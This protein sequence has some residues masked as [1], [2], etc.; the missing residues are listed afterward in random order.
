MNKNTISLGRIFGIPLNV[1]SSWFLI[2][3]LLSWMLAS[4]YYPREF[5]GWPLWQYW[6]MGMFTS[7][8]LFVSVLLHELG[9]SLVAR[10]F[11]LPVQRIT[12]FVFGGIAQIAGEP[13][14]ARAEFWIALAGPIVSFALAALFHLITP[15]VQGWDALF[16]FFKY[17]AFI[18]LILAG[19]N[20]IPGF[21]LDGGRIFRSILWGITKNL[22]KATF[23]AANVGRFFAFAFIFLG[24][25]QIIAGHIMDGLWTIFIGLFLE[26]A[27]SSQIQQQE[28][29]TLLVRHKV[30]EAM[31]PNFAIVPADSSLQEIVDHHVLGM[32]RRAV[33]VV[34]DGE[35]AGM[36]TLH[37]LKSVSPDK[38]PQVRVAE[39]MLPASQ[40]R[41]VTPDTDLW[42][43]LQAMDRD[44]VNQLPVLQDGKLVG[45]ITRGDL[46]SFLNYLH[47]LST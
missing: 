2:F 7:I 20:L 18:N 27:A 46:I 4:N 40:M 42:S 17:L 28:M 13:P 47:S 10:H 1:D 14:S 8:F 35:I 41:W 33:I 38:W 45:I 11:H 19:F 34:D 39:V 21:P 44:G 31:N 23:I 37:H 36:L 22:R 32:G 24:A 29:R 6:F 25:M 3:A 26:S 5:P 15:L 12:L 43:A 9:H 30:N 16:A